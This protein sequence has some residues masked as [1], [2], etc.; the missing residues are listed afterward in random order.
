M[1]TEERARKAV[2]LGVLDLDRVWFEEL[3]GVD[4]VRLFPEEFGILQRLDLCT[5]DD[6]RIRLT[7]RGRKYRDIIVQVFFS[8]T[9]RRRLAGFRYLE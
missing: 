8:D 3:T 6:D 2:I 4:A 9:V 7:E 1:S 5:I